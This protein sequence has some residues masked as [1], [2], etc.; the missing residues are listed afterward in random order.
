MVVVGAKRGELA[1]IGVD[2]GI[3]QIVGAG[4]GKAWW[5]SPLRRDPDFCALYAA[6]GLQQFETYLASWNAYSDYV[7]RRA[8]E[9][10]A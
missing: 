6:E 2:L 1:Q 5:R 4:S 9:T 10:G 7:A 3:E 8:N